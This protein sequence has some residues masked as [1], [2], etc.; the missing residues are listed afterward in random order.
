M[1]KRTPRRPARPP[2]PD[3]ETAARALRRALRALGDGDP[4]GRLVQSALANVD[5]R[6]GAR[7][8]VEQP[9]L[10][11]RRADTARGPRWQLWS[12]RR[13]LH[14]GP[15]TGRRALPLVQVRAWALGRAAHLRRG[16]ID[17]L[18]ETNGN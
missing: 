13:V 2:G 5:R 8:P 6:R 12:G 7:P 10:E 14:S 4:A 1:P 16:L 17:K 18:E 9:P 11:L 15:M 3:L